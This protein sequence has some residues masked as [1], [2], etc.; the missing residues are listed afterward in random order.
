M[1]QKKL[2]SCLLNDTEFLLENYPFL[3]RIN[4][5]DADDNETIIAYRLFVNEPEDID[6]HFRVRQNG[7]WFEKSGRSEVTLCSTPLFEPWED[8]EEICYTSPIV[9][10][11][12]KHDKI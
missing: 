11:R 2:R 12:V 3:E 6:F 5:E 7:F 1:T 8:S 4:F 9:F 10:F